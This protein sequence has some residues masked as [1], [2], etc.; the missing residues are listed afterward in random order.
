[1]L[2]DAACNFDADLTLKRLCGSP[3]ALLPKAAITVVHKIT[4]ARDLIQLAGWE[5]LQT[6]G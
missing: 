1:M 3:A 2:G 6:V 5:V 4:A